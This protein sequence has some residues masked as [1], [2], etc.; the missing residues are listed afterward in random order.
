MT[1]ATRSTRPRSSSGAGAPS[2]RERTERHDPERQRKRK[3]GDPEPD[4]EGGSATDESG[5]VAE[6]A[7]PERSAPTLVPLEPAG[8]PLRLCRGV[9]EPRPGGAEGGPPRADDDVAGLV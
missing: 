2:A 9:Q 1:S 8:R 5:L 3:P 7:R 6:S 4:A